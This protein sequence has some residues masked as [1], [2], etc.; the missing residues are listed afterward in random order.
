[1]ILIQNIYYMLSYSFKVLNAQGYKNLKTEEFANVADLCAAILVQGVSLQL[2]KGL[3]REYLPE[4][5]VLSSVRGKIDITSSVKNQTLLKKQLVCVFDDFSVNTKMNQIIKSTMLVLLKSE[6]AKARKKEIK[7]L[8]VFFAEVEVLDIYTINWNVK[9][10]KTNESYRMLIS[11]CY[12][13]IKGLLQSNT[14]G[15]TKLMDFD[16]ENKARLYEKFILEY[17]KKEYPELSVS[18]SRIPWNVDNDLN[19]L[20]PVMQ[21]DIMLRYLNKILIIDAK[22]Y[23]E[24]LATRYE[25]PSIISSNL[26]QIFT[27]TKNAQ[28]NE[29]DKIVS[30][31]LLY[32]ATDAKV[33]PDNSFLMFGNQISVKTLDLMCD[34]SSIK[35]SLN[36]IVDSYFEL[37]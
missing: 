10:N 26:Y 28:Y 20:L 31:M 5:E 30:G 1:M 16:E 17:Y 27:Y 6:V 4:A 36:S 14:A 25:K 8:L 23:E 21:S 37:A 19:N 3:G 2:K 32:A 7:K 12:L 18:S 24:N 34:F 11:I 33:Q 22:Y 9:F 13:V 35:E 29:M 15:S